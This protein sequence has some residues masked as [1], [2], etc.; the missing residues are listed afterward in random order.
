MA[1]P[2]FRKYNTTNYD[3]IND[4]DDFTAEIITDSAADEL[5]MTPNNDYNN[6][7]IADGDKYLDISG[8]KFLSDGVLADTEIKLNPG[9]YEGCTVDFD[10]T[11]IDDYGDRHRLSDFYGDV[12]G[13]AEEYIDALGEYICNN[14]PEHK[15]T[16]ALIRKSACRRLVEGLNRIAGELDAFCEKMA[17]DTLRCVCI[18]S[19]GEA[20]YQRC[21]TAKAAANAI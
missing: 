16:W 13:L 7:A 3:V 17:D 12:D 14:W 6:D 10:I 1:T 21:D 15:G 20:V 5:G 11:L 2:K 4:P 9:Y 19:N 18:F 8:W